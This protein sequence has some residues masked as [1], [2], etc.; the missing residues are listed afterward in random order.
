MAQLVQIDQLRAEQ[1]AIS[2]QLGLSRQQ[3]PAAAS[4]QQPA[5]TASQQQPMATTLQQQPAA[6][7]S[8]QQPGSCD[9]SPLAPRGI[10]RINPAHTELGL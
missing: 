4:Q 3:Q 9:H 8:Q 10:Y 5:A 7:A 1:Q 6:T 2:E